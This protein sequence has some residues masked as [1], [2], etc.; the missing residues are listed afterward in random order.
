ME[1]TKEQ[2]VDFCLGQV[3]RGYKDVREDCEKHGKMPHRIKILAI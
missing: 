3:I 2:N 1:G